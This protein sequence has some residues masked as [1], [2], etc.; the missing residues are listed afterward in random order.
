MGEAS[1]LSAIYNLP[2]LFFSQLLMVTGEP[3]ADGPY[4]QRPVGPVSRHGAEH[5]PI[6]LV[7]MAAF[8][9]QDPRVN[10]RLVTPHLAKVM[11]LN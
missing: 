5:V 9:V 6:Q 10:R 3:G 4:V 2:G 1:V 11:Q 8:L 7:R